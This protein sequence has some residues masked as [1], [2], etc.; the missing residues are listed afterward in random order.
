[1]ITAPGKYEGCP[2]WAPLVAIL[3]PTIEIEGYRRYDAIT[4]SELLALPCAEAI[5]EDVSPFDL[6]REAVPA[7]VILWED[8]NGFCHCVMSDHARTWADIE[9]LYT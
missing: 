7:M 5:L 8:G 6:M 2:W 9:R 1:M 4:R 3:D